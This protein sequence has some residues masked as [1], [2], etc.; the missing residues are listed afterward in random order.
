MHKKIPTVYFVIAIA[1]VVII[2]GVIFYREVVYKPETPLM[3]NMYPR[4]S[5]PKTK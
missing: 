1:V 5:T 3:T 4:T 2:I